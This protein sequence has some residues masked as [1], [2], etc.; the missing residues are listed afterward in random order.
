MTWTEFSQFHLIFP[1][2][3]VANY[4]PKAFCFLDKSSSN[5]SIFYW[6]AASAS[7]SPLAIVCT[8]KLQTFQRASNQL[9]WVS[10]WTGHTQALFRKLK[11]L[12]L[13]PQYVK[14]AAICMEQILGITMVGL[15][16]CDKINTT[17]SYILTEASVLNPSLYINLGNSLHVLLRMSQ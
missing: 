3:K 13:S 16:S 10:S 15:L 14:M 6:A 5:D 4:Q 12:H 11:P 2:I 7:P 1:K 9:Y 17:S 8:F